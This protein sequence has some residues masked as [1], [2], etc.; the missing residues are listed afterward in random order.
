MVYTRHRR[1]LV[2]KH[3]YQKDTMIKYFDNLP[4]PQLDEPKWTSYEKKVFGMVKDMDQ[5][6]FEKKKKEIEETTT[7]K[8]KWDKEEPSIAAPFKKK[9]IFFKYLSY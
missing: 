5:V 9:S 8:R 3:S 7:R 6:K 4:K 1:F 2:K